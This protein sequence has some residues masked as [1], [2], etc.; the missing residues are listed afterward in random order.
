MKILFLDIL[1]GNPELRKNINQKIYKGGSYGEHLRKL[2]SLKK[3]EWAEVDASQKIPSDFLKFDGIVIGGSTEDPM[4][5][6][7]KP[8]MKKIY[9]AIRKI[10]KNKIPLLGICGGLQFTARALGG[11]VILNPGGREFGSVKITLSQDG[12]KDFLFCGISKNFTAQSSHKCMVEKILPG[13]RLLA[14]S[15]M[16]GLQALSLGDRA[17]LLQF[18]PEKTKAQLKSLAKMRKSALIAEGFVQ[19]EKDFK[20]FLASIKNTETAGKKILKNFINFVKF[21]SI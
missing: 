8:W 14:S 9:P 13:S 1:T 10:I 21:D 3:S 12:K 19:D 17:R 20:K 18:H 16:C 6:S 4:P 2:F 5:G 7:E 15:D 11:K